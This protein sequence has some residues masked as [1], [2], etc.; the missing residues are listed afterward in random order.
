[1]T[2]EFSVEHQEIL[3]NSEIDVLA[4]MSKNY[5]HAHFQFNTEEWLQNDLKIVATF[6]QLESRDIYE[7]TVPRLTGMC[8]IPQEVLKYPGF[9]ISLN[10][11]A[12]KL[13]ITTKPE[14]VSLYK[15]GPTEGNASSTTYNGPSINLDKYPKLTLNNMQKTDADESLVYIYNPN[16]NKGYTMALSQLVN[17]DTY[18]QPLVLN[19]K[20]KADE[21]S[22][23][24]TDQNKNYSLT[25]SSLKEYIVD[26]STKITTVNEMPS[27]MKVGDYIFLKS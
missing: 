10:G 1:M 16:E 9:K 22:L 21:I 2:L 5:L 27:D 18:T 19:D 11:Y 4:D 7:M 6:K 23:L 12:D 26:N 13:L 15:A 25:L 8:E 20:T 3:L 24:A 17:S 14:T